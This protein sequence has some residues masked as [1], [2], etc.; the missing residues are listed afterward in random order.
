MPPMFA[1]RVGI[2]SVTVW[3]CNSSTP[4][5]PVRLAGSPSD[6]LLMNS[7]WPRPLPIWAVDTRGR[8]APAAP[9]RF[10]WAS[11]DSV[12]V[13]STGYVT[14]PKSADFGVEAILGR[15]T[16]RFFV[17]CRQ[18]KYVVMPGPIQFV[19]G[20]SEWSHPRTLLYGVYGYDKELVSLFAAKLLVGDSDVAALR[21]DTLYPRARGITF[22][23]VNIGDGEG[24]TGVHIYERVGTAA[25]D[26]LA[27]TPIP[28]RKLAVPIQLVNGAQYRHALPAG[29]W[30]LS[31]LPRGGH[32]VN[33]IRLEVQGAACVKNL[34]NDPG[35]LGCDL[36]SPAT[37]VVY[38][39]AA[40][41]ATRPANVYL[42][43][44]WAGSA[45]DTTVPPLK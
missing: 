44:R 5:L 42:L 45:W 10:E 13:S 28:A 38:R 3:A 30:M 36:R 43:V 14:C 7:R 24:G 16:T 35:R 11:G 18:V 31:L 40:T 26:S 33:P 15:V 8:R 27:R 12:P 39:P 20:D 41:I 29:H 9:I 37:I 25:L 4:G 21:G 23:Q 2:L 19:M 34:L 1:M 17:H 32:A 6:T 22:V